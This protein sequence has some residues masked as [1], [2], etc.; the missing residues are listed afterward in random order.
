MATER[1]E[2]IRTA[3]FP[4]GVIRAY[5]PARAEN[6]GPSMPNELQCTS[7]DQARSK[8]VN[9]RMLTRVIYQKKRV[10]RSPSL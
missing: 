4:E 10:L 8:K 7:T 2:R 1:M 6:P 5:R 3:S 9:Q